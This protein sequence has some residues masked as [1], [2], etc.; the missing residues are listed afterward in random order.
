MRRSLVLCIV[1]LIVVNAQV[2]MA[3][4]WQI[5]PDGSG[6]APTIQAGLDSAAT[7]DTVLVMPG[8]YYEN[9]FW[10][11]RNGIALV[12][13]GMEN[14]IVVGDGVETVLYM[15]G[16]T[17]SGGGPGEASLAFASEH[18][19]ISD[20][21]LL[22]VPL[23]SSTVVK[24][25][26]FRGG[27]DAGV[28]LYGASPIVEFCRVDSTDP[29]P[30]I[31]AMSGSWVQIR[32]CEVVSNKGSGIRLTECGTLLTISGST[33][34]ANSAAADGGG[35]SCDYS[36]PTITSNTIT[37]NS[38]SDYGGGIAC[39]HS[40]PTITSNTITGN[41]ANDGG[42]ISC[43]SSSPI[44]T[45]NT[46]IG[47]S[48]NYGGGISCYY[49]SSPIISSN[50]ITTNSANYYGG[51]IY[52]Y[53]SSPSITSNPITAN[54]ANYGGGISCGHYSSPTITTNSIIRN[55]ATSKGGAFSCT[56]NS[57]PSVSLN[58]I[59]E[60]AAPLG[61]AI[62]TKDSKPTISHSNIAFNG[63]G[64]HNASYGTVPVAQNNWWR[65]PSGPWHRGGN[66]GGQ[67]DSLSTYAWDFVPWL[68]DA[69]TTA[70]PIPPQ[71]LVVV[72]VWHVSVTLSWQ[73]VPLADLAGYKVYFD[74]D[75][76][77]W[78]GESVDVG[79][80]TEFTLEDLESDTTYYFAVTCYDSSGNESWYS[81]QVSAT[82]GDVS[83]VPKGDRFAEFRITSLKPNPFNSQ[84]V[85]EYLLPDARR[86]RVTVHDVRGR[87]I[88]MLRDGVEPAGLGTS[89]WDGKDSFGMVCSPGI[90]YIRIE[91]GKE[92]ATSKVVLIR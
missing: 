21:L 65:H 44:I 28:V 11:F 42:G 18:R 23:D 34:T 55:I 89:F 5:F 85:L 81:A 88:R 9:L 73:P 58:T 82:T 36:S 50:A 67:G 90:Y 83:G 40:S 3:R 32:Q 33:I 86:A 20:A 84:V 63:W 43:Y 14:T 76:T 48:A 72:G 91:S 29:G 52:C 10:P 2:V 19:K 64:M 77:E 49:Y 56:F 38:A 4:T 26:T 79:N 78:Y 45:S 75:T 57:N 69:D 92:V 62:Y 7:G 74:T 60:N 24:G 12:G 66:P 30:G 47:N 71:D 87:Q 61:D 6:D 68:A 54:S 17:S 46:I 31:H 22:A 37:A 59:T 8:T 80:V 15:V 1:L 53:Y 35:I 39:D 27:G 70:P 13:G 41:S 25:L 16:T 51:G